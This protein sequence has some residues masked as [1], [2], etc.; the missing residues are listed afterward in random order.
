MF[1]RFN[2]EYESKV[3]FEGEIDVSYYQGYDWN[4]NLFLRLIYV[5]KD[6]LNLFFS[7]RHLFRAPSF[8]EVYYISPANIGNPSLDVEKIDNFE[9]GLTFFF[10]DSLNLN[11]N[12]FLRKHRD[13]IDWVKDSVSSAWQATNIG[14]LK[15]KGLDLNLTFKPNNTFINQLNVDYT[16]LDSEDNPY[17]FSKYLF[18]Y[19]KH[20]VVF[21][22]QTSL[23]GFN[24]NLATIFSKPVQ[25]KR[26]TA[27]NLKMTKN[28]FSNLDL[29]IEGTN[30]FNKNYYEL[31]DIKGAPRWYKVGVEY[32][33]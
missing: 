19:L 24:L 14:S 9:T 33:F 26:F 10:K 25:R 16:Y 30:I 4:E 3:L 18:D 20:K 5:A 13:A 8:T 32:K 17:N 21:N 12:L 2:P 7:F 15:V 29:F 1:I 23:L 22:I 28:I 11:F 31:T 6:N 27:C